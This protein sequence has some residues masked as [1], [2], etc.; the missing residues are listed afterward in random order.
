MELKTGARY[1]SAVDDTE[2]IV[3]S[4]AGGDVDLRCGG[5]PMLDI[6][7]AEPRAPGAGAAGDSPGTK[8]G[9]RYTDGSIE[10]LVTKGGVTTLS[11]A[12]TPLSI[13][14]ARPLPSSD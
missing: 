13:K 6:Q 4:G 11:V 2:V 9:K 10:L 5:Q 12:G 14:E 1:R 8:L 3:V 7:S